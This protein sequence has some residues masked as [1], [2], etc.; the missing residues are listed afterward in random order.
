MTQTAEEHVES[1]AAPKTFDFVGALAKT[2]YPSEDVTVFLD[3]A[4]AK[5]LQDTIIAQEEA[6]NKIAGLRAVQQGIVE[7]PEIE[8]LEARVAELKAEAKAIIKAI[9]ASALTF[10]LKGLAPEQWRLIG[11]SWRRKIKPVSKAEDDVI[12]ADEL[13]ATK[14]N[15]EILATSILKVTNAEGAV[16]EGAVTIE[17]VEALDNQLEASEFERLINTANKL[18]FARGQFNTLIAQDADFLSND[19]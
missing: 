13:R 10:S 11:K 7:D 17:Q 18:T 14:V 3:G 15:A 8:K 19:S 2:T 4:R 9:H 5:E 12:D 16:N 1:L 6:E